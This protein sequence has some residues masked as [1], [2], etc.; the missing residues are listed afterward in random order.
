[1][2]A[3]HLQKK[4]GQTFIIE[5]KSGAGGIIGTAFVA[6]APPNGGVFGVSIAGPMALNALLYKSMSYDLLKDW[7]RL[8]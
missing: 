1:M 2:V 5:S 8:R 7:Y 6:K 3:D 4:S